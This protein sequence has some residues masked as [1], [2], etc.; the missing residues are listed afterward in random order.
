MLQSS[1]VETVFGAGLG[2]FIFGITMFIGGVLTIFL[3]ETNQQIMPETIA[4][5]NV[6]MAGR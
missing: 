4:E 6:F 2:T 1:E 3:P 5:A